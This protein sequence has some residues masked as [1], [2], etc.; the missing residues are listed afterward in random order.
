[1]NVNILKNFVFKGQ[2]TLFNINDVKDDSSLVDNFNKGL[3]KFFR[4]RITKWE[5]NKEEYPQYMFL[6]GDR[7]ILAYVD[8][9]EIS[10]TAKFDETS[11]NRDLEKIKDQVKYAYSDLDRPIFFIYLISCSDY[12]D[13]LFETSDQIRDKLLNDKK[14]LGWNK[15]KY[16]PNKHQMGDLKNLVEIFRD[17][18]QNKR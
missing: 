3:S 10:C 17:M 12:E 18:R 7:G 9:I 2:E 6:A 11:L 1:M 16:I 4:L 14:S 5:P 15:G 8:F 13:I